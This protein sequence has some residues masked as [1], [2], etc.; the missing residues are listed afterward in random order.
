MPLLYSEGGNKAFRRL[1]EEVI[2]S[3]TDHNVFAANAINPVVQLAILVESVSATAG[4]HGIFTSV[5]DGSLL[6]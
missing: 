1:Q 3:S 2:R 6:G 5:I 4:R